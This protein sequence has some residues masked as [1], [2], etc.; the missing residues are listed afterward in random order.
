MDI[1]DCIG[2]YTPGGWRRNVRGA[3]GERG[4][5]MLEAR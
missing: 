2:E 3:L 5:E 4:R 1:A